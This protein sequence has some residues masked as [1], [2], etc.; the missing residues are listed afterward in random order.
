M[1]ARAGHR[2]TRP[3][4]HTDP[5]EGRS[6]LVGGRRTGLAVLEI[7]TVLVEVGCREW[8]GHG[9]VVP[10]ERHRERSGEGKVSLRRTALGV[11]EEEVDSILAGSRDSLV[12]VA[13]DCSL[14]AGKA[15]AA[16]DG[17]LGAAGMVNL[18]AEG[19]RQ[20]LLLK[21]KRNNRPLTRRAMRRA[22][23]RS[24]VIV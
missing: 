19:E 11:V 8:E 23:R 21:A 10:G 13:L 24:W 5:A 15:A 9:Y 22:L 3:G 6:C 20:S 4:G 7:R 2:R 12:E 14:A 1:A 18:C 16:E 17:C